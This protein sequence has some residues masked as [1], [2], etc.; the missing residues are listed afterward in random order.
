MLEIEVAEVCGYCPLYK[1]GDKI[2]V[3]DPE[4]VSGN[5]T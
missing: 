4:M 3:D 5:E 1:V 2:V